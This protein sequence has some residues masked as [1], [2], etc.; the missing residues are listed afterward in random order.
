MIDWLLSE[1]QY[2]DSALS[3]FCPLPVSAPSRSP[4]CHYPRRISER[5]P[6]QRGSSERPRARKLSPDSTTGGTARPS[7]IL[8]LSAI[9]SPRQSITVARDASRWPCR[10][11]QDDHGVLSLRHDCLRRSA[12]QRQM[13]PRKTAG[14]LDRGGAVIPVAC[15]PRTTANA[16]AGRRYTLILTRNP[17]SAPITHTLDIQFPASFSI[18]RAISRQA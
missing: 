18:S 9:A 3:T 16:F 5:N 7:P 8:A 13:A 4:I 11:G 12:S 15:W 1:V 6:R 2:D 10:V 14:R 17:Q